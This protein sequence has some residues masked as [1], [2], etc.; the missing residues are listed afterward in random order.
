MNRHS[1][2]H[3]HTRSNRATVLH[4]HYTHRQ[5]SEHC[6]H[7]CLCLLPGSLFLVPCS[8]A[9]LRAALRICHATPRTRIKFKL[10][11]NACSA[12]TA[13]NKGSCAS[14]ARQ[15]GRRSGK[16]KGKKPRL[17]FFL[18]SLH[19]IFFPRAL[20]TFALAFSISLRRTQPNTYAQSTPPPSPSFSTPYSNC[21]HLVGCV[22]CDSS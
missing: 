17:T 19:L 3:S 16:D 12:I 22:I 2:T 6:S 8:G 9:N 11:S 1:H 18:R 20:L 10:T 13:A 5:V 15:G 7:S 4:I 14:T 21:C